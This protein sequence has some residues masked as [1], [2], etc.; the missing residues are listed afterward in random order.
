MIGQVSVACPTK[1]SHP[2]LQSSSIAVPLNCDQAVLVPLVG[3]FSID[4]ADGSEN[5]MCKM[6][7]RFS[8]FVTSLPIC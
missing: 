2:P 5:V 3:S 6:N 4:N 8:N 7:L 1:R